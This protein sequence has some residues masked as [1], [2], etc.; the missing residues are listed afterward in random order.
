MQDAAT[1]KITAKPYYLPIQEEVEVFQKA[2][3][4]KVPVLL[5]GPTGCGKT[6]RKSVV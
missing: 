3:V 5:K 2:W 4:E 1:S 6:D